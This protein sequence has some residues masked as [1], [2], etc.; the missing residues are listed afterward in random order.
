MTADVAV[1]EALGM[2]AFTALAQEQLARGELIGVA[3][4]LASAPGVVPDPEPVP[5]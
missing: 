4:A 2:L 3:A 5:A 1:V